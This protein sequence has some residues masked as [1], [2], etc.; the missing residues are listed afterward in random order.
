VT[1]ELNV[2]AGAYAL[3]ALDDDERAVFEEHLRTCESCT[4]EVAGLRL[5]AA[6]LNHLTETAPP[7]QL[8]GQVLSAISQVRPLP[9]VPDNLIA[10]RRART[11]RSVWQ[12]VAAACALVAIVVS[13]WGYSQHRDATR[14]ASV[15]SSMQALLHAPDLKVRTTA[16]RQGSGT[17]LYS[18]GEQRVMLIGQGLPAPAAGKTYQLWMLSASGKAVSA[19]T[20]R[21]DHAGNVQLPVN[22]DLSGFARMA[23]SVEPAGGSQSPTLSTV[24]LLNL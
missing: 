10:L 15:Q 14:T 3:D 11:S 1:D 4:D 23:I 18:T 17:L 13:G 21:P 9:P 22:G 20:F 7:A 6:E 12:L 16:L 19:A 2:L 5:A 24:Q 8:R